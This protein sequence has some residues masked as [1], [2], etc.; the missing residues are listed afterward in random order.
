MISGV[1]CH[2]AENCGTLAK[3]QTFL[4]PILYHWWWCTVVRKAHTHAHYFLEGPPLSMSI[5]F[6]F[7]HLDYNSPVFV[8]LAAIVRIWF[9]CDFT[10]NIFPA[11]SSE[12]VLV[13]WFFVVRWLHH[14]SDRISVESQTLF[15]V[16]RCCHTARN[17]RISLGPSQ[18][19]NVRLLVR[20]FVC[21]GFLFINRNDFTS[22]TPLF[23]VCSSVC[24]KSFSSDVCAEI[25]LVIN[26][27]TINFGGSLKFLFKIYSNERKVTKKKVGCSVQ[28][29]K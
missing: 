22:C 16:S 29:I 12:F 19:S 6:A 20:L 7:I 27:H 10:S 4:F 2:R 11:N 13:Q 3:T 8:H 23:C 18:W 28:M 14:H 5:S 25:C 15:L 17:E 26:K 21:F 1:I 9:H 24:R